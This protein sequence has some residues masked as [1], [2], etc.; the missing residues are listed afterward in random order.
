MQIQL[1]DKV[2][3]IINTLEEAGYEAYAVGGCVRDSILGRKPD[4][5]DITTSA[6]PEEI[7][8]LFPRTVD[9]G[10]KHGTVTVLLGGEGFEV[11]TYRVDGVYEDGRHP[12]EV[13]FTASL[14]EDL[15]RRDFTINAMAYNARTGLVDLYGGL[16][17]IENRVIRCVGIA[18]ERFDE[19][20]LRMLRAVRFSAQLSFR[21][22]EATGEAVK[23]LAPNLQKISAERI[24]VEL[25]KLVTSPNPDYLRTAYELGITAQILPEFDLCMETPQRHKH[26]CYDVGEHILHSMIEVG[27]DK[28]LRL[29]MLFHDIGKPQTLTIDPDGTTHNKRHPFEGEK[30]TRKV[31]RRLK[32]DNDTTDKVTKLVLYH[33]YDI[34]PTEAG[35]RRA[36]NRMGED[37][38]AMIFT[39]RR[40]D[41]AAQSDYMREEKLAKVAYIEKLYS[42]ILARK[43]AVTLKDLAI[44]GNDLIAEGMP[45]GRQIGETLSALLER[46]LDDPSLNTREILLKLYKEV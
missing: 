5:W 37:I 28:V 35:V 2:H 15:K 25:V 1:P 26:H 4:D 36:I 12:S 18:G 21:I 34:A 29:G 7:K 16:A 14:K 9:T 6:K 32:F 30:I 10:I 8:R 38:F 19:D 45:P 20:A 17:D 27:P 41:I 23:A 44:S 46:V 33:D 39:V 42:E 22:E 40:A 13:T 43:D 31:M 24:Q 3:H 11:T